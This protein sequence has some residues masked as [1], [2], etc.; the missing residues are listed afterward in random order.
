[1][2]IWWS[3]VI[4]WSGMEKVRSGSLLTVLPLCFLL[5][6]AFAVNTL[7]FCHWWSFSHA[8]A[9]DKHEG[10]FYHV[11]GRK[12]RLLISLSFFK[13]ISFATYLYHALF[14]RIKVA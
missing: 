1:M 5:L 2:I 6:L 8:I 14:Y 10:A 13:E 12:P 11:Q 4:I 9:L 3:N 7:S